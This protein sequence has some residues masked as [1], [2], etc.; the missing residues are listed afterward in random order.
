VD[1]A[2]HP[3]EMSPRQRLGEV[4]RLLAEGI[5]RRR[6]REARN[7]K[8]DNGFGENR[9]EA[10]RASRTHGLEPARNGEGP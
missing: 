4:A 3:D 10:M 6:L 5:L 9:L 2:L 1:N 7:P 8:I